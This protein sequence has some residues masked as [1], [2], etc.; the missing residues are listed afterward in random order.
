MFG[1]SSVKWFFCFILTSILMISPV[2]AQQDTVHYEVGVQSVLSTGDA[3]PFWIQNGRHGTV[4]F[5]PS[6]MQLEL[7]AQKNY[8]HPNR[9]FDY[10]VGFKGHMGTLDGELELKFHEYYLRTR[11][12]VFNANIGA[13]E[14]HFGVQ[15]ESLSSGGLLFSGNTAPLP[16]VFVGIEEFTP[17]PYTKG[18]LELKGGLSHGWFMDDVYVKDMLFHH[19]LAY[20][21]LGGKGML[22]FQ[23]GFEHAAQWGGDIPGHGMQP[24]G[25]KDFMN[26]LLLRSGGNSTVDGE[27]INMGG[28]HLVMQNMRFD[29]RVK[30]TEIAAY[31]QAINEDKP[32]RMMWSAVNIHDG[33]WGFSVKNK[34]FPIVKGFLYE[35]LNTTDQ[36]GP[37]HD[38]DG[39]VFGGGDSYYTNYLYKSGWTHYGRVF[40]TPL[41]TSP[42]Y[43]TDGSISLNNTRVQ[44]HHVGLEGEVGGYEF[45]ILNSF[46]KNY[47]NYGAPLRKDA[48]SLLV[49]IH[50][51]FEKLWNLEAGLSLGVDWGQ[52]YGKNTGVMLRVVKRGEFFK[53]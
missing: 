17:M 34:T 52:M 19:K 42:V 46:S 44:V 24:S 33:L 2:I 48:V 40:G 26:I 30:D 6:S 43:N 21:R 14:E 1:V 18:F 51:Q 13:R 49:E 28:N 22:R 7:G 50:K 4:A 41:I 32:I 53:Y 12:W 8:Q 5:D 25:F 38:K 23:Y 9:L 29:L 37:Y 27:Q 39:I 31:W 3:A 36:N 15:D 20:F 35:Y 47:G 11:L 45:K 10:S 16:K